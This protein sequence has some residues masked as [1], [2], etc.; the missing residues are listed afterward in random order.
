MGRQQTVGVRSC[1]DS[2]VRRML[3]SHVS[4]FGIERTLAN[5][6]F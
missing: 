2:E 4:N 5:L 1:P 6:L 3:R